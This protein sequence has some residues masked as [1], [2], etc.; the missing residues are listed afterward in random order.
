MTAAV[1]ADMVPRSPCREVR[2]PKVEREEMRFLNP[3]EVARL[4]DLIDAR[5]RALVLVAA[6]GGLR[7]GELAGLRRRR[8]DLLRARLMWPR[9]WSRSGASCRWAAQDPRR[10]AHRHPAPVG[11]RGAGRAPGPV[12]EAEAWMFTADKGGSC[13]HPT[14]GSRSGCRPSGRPGWRRCGPTTSGCRWAS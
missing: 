10:P 1:N 12:G 6:Y 11:G 9:S 5:Y 3:A 4:A 13:G 14:S 8:V 2:L 7:I